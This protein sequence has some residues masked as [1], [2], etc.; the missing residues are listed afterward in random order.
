MFDNLNDFVDANVPKLEKSQSPSSSPHKVDKDLIMN[1]KTMSIKAED[2]LLKETMEDDANKT[3][4]IFGNLSKNVMKSQIIQNRTATDVSVHLTENSH[5]KLSSSHRG[6]G[7]SSSA[8]FKGAKNRS[9]SN[10]SI[11]SAISKS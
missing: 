2:S 9:K 1:S 5:Q 4:E 11:R 8:T 6:R 10:S 3:N 7:G